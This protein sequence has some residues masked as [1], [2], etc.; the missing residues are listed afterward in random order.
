MFLISLGVYILVYPIFKYIL[1]PLLP[2]IGSLTHLSFI[3]IYAMAYGITR[4]FYNISKSSNEKIKNILDGIIATKGVAFLSA[5]TFLVSFVSLV[6]II[7]WKQ[8][9][10]NTLQIDILVPIA[11]ASALETLKAFFGYDPEPNCIDPNKPKNP[12]IPLP[13]IVP[14]VIPTTP[15]VNP[16]DNGP[17]IEKNYTWEFESEKYQFRQFILKDSYESYKNRSRNTDYRSWAAEYVVKG[18]S[19]EVRDAAKNLYRFCK[20]YGTWSEVHFIIEFVHQIVKYES[21]IDTTGKPEYPRYPLESMVDQ[22]GD[23]EDFSIFGAAILKYM[24]YDV[25]LLSMSGHEAMGVAGVDGI[26]GTY[27]EH[28]G[29]KYYFCEMTAKGWKIGQM[30][31]E[32]N[33]KRIEVFPI[34]GPGAKVVRKE[35]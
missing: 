15:D 30:S 34:P 6:L 28:N 25:A 7:L 33:E 12:D 32:H 26:P 35:E 14:G 23:C 5:A 22:K 29:T 18:M 8:N 1:F 24:G 10:P 27:I 3:L 19:S 20:K 2:T 13:N 21:D 11:F 9:F 31:E 16:E 17:V 4:L